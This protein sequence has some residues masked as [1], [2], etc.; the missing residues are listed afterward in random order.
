MTILARFRP[1]G[2]MMRLLP[3]IAT[4]ACLLSLP[5]TAEAQFRG[6]D[7]DSDRSEGDRRRGDDGGGGDRG[8]FDWRQ[9][10]QEGG[11]REGGDRSSRWSGFSRDGGGDSGRSGFGGGFGPPGGFGGGFGPPGGFG[12]GFG[13]PGGFGG[14]GGD[15]GGWGG[16]EGGRPS[17]EFFFGRLDR[18]G[19]GKLNG[20]EIEGAGFFRGML[21]RAGIQEGAT[22]DDFSKGFE[23]ARA[24]R[25]RGE[26]GGSGRDRNSRSA[27]KYYVPAKKERVTVDLPDDYRDRDVDGDGQI[28]LYE[29]REWDR[30]SID[31]FFAYDRNGDGFLTPKEVAAGPGEAPAEDNGRTAVADRGPVPQP[32]DAADDAQVRKG[33]QAFS[34]VDA[35]KDGKASPDELTRINKL[36]AGFEKAGAKFD[37]EMTQDQ[38][39]AYYVQAA[40]R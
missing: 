18:D 19:D 7:G 28:G 16:S 17:P 23:Q 40:P 10:F 21:E 6:R 15:R 26:D 33:K 25:E 35:N 38:F 20:E 39:V 27:P 24:E 1:F 37:Q 34:I 36:R 29:W 5:Y 13:P 9:R 32:M 3:G 30:G 4:V 12:G 8:G 2:T 14:P 31:E 22:R 11:D